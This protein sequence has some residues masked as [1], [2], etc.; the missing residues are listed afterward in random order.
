MA[1]AAAGIL[2]AYA[3][4]A[5]GGLGTSSEIDAEAIAWLRQARSHRK[6][7]RG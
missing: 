6:T 4:L 2:D 3:R 7:G 5:Y 1:E